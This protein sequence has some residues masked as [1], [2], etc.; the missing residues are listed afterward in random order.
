[1]SRHRAL[2]LAVSLATVVF[3]VRPS[4]ALSPPDQYDTFTRAKPLIRDPHTNLEWQRAISPVFR[5]AAEA[6]AYCDGL[7]VGSASDFR[8]PSYLELASLVDDEPAGL[9]NG[10]NVVYYAIDLNAFPDTPAETFWA[11][12]LVVDPP[13]DSARW[14]IDFSNGTS[15]PHNPGEGLLVRC[16]RDAP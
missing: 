9:S 3:F 13:T 12:D 7:V 1:M 6:T 10:S 16:V 4:D 14:A 8:V 15:S 5:D 2:S 11:A